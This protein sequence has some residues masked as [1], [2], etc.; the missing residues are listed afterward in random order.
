MGVNVWF[1]VPER[2][3]KNN[4]DKSDVYRRFWDNFIYLF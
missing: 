4:I 2:D 1:C 3:F